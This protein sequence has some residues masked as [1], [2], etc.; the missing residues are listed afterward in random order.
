MAIINYTAAA[1]GSSISGKPIYEAEET[2]S[3]AGNGSTIMLADG[4]GPVESIIVSLII[5]SGEGKLQTTASNVTDVKDDNANWV[6]WDQG[7]VTVTTTDVFYNV[8]AI[9]AVN[10]SGTIKIEARAV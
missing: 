5:N 10:V 3:G 6:D 9:R 8:T 4:Q 1:Q 7:S 2:L